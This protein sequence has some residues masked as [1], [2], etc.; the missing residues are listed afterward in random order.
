MNSNKEQIDKICNEASE[1]DED[2]RISFLDSACEGDDALRSSVEAQ[3]RSEIAMTADMSDAEDASSQLVTG[4]ALIG[5]TIGKFNIVGIIGQGGMGCVYEAVQ[6][7]PKRTVALKVMKMGVSSD[8]A[9]RR[10]EL[11]SQ[12]LA[13]L[14]HQGIA[15]VHDAGTWEEEG[16]TLPWFAMEYIPNALEITTYVE[17]KKL[18][19]N[20]RL[21]L[22]Q[23]V[24]DAVHH[25][26]QK[27]II[28]RDLKPGNILVD[29][30]GQPKIIDFGVARSTDSDMNA[31]T[32]Q[33]SVGQLVGTLQYMSPEQCDANPHDIDTRSD[34]YAL[35]VIL[36]ELLCKVWPYNLSR[37]SIYEAARIIKE[38]PPLHPKHDNRKLP[39]DVETILFKA[40][41]K[42]RNRRYP[43]AEALGE[44]IRRYLEHEPIIARPPSFLYQ[45]TMFCKRHRT[46]SVAT[47]IG[48]LIL[49]IGVPLLVKAR[50]DA[51]LSEANTQN[52]EQIATMEHDRRI[53]EVHE[54]VGLVAN[55]EEDIRHLPASE[56]TR[57]VLLTRII[58]RLAT[59]SEQTENDPIVQ[60]ELAMSWERLANITIL[61]EDA[62][63]LQTRLNAWD[64]AITLREQLGNLLDETGTRYSKSGYLLGLTDHSIL[65]LQERLQVAEI[66]KEELLWC[67]D[68][69]DFKLLANN[70]APFQ[71]LLD[72][73]IFEC[74]EI[75]KELRSQLMSA[76]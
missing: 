64:N 6:D 2:S 39:R 26:H 18:S 66:A 73:E 30:S 53:E 36:Y 32:L 74:D 27:G 67:K 10:F 71:E 25:G 47:F 65:S 59:L 51:K 69:G 49:S 21:T 62:D 4:K 19:L 34:V 38:E 1:L 56:H 8:I 52:A 14:K 76:Q 16:G 9:L 60:E 45:S 20:E 43:S 70:N 44:D 61:E 68:Y 75:I 58:E 37:T 5:S 17:E 22:F 46:A 31:A 63:A 35:G 28:H 48:I 40:L 72:E 57:V 12:L 54:L 11:E 50:G 29:S 41:E 23:Q 55:I 7:Q 15:Q 42:D 24:C 13:R 3:L 33:T